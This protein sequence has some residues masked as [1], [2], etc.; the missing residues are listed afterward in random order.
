MGMFNDL[1]D[2]LDNHEHPLMRK[3]REDE[4]AGFVNHTQPPNLGALVGA[5]DSAKDWMMRNDWDTAYE[6]QYDLEVLAGEG[7]GFE[8]AEY[9]A[10][11]LDGNLEQDCQEAEERLE[12]LRHL[13]PERWHEVYA[14]TTDER[15]E[16]D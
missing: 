2:T 8:I 11:K 10:D 14:H 9:L 4:E 15:S 1:L 16:D 6:I 7:V 3:K 5:D 12:E 13:P